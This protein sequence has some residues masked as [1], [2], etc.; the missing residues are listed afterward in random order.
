MS[1]ITCQKYGFSRKYYYVKTSETTCYADINLPMDWIM[2]DIRTRNDCGPAQC[3][4]CEKLLFNG[5][6]VYYC[7]KCLTKLATYGITDRGT[8]DNS[9]KVTEDE[10]LW[11]K[12]PYMAGVSMKNIGKEKPAIVAPVEHNSLNDID[13]LDFDSKRRENTLKDY[14][15][16]FDDEEDHERDFHTRLDAYPDYDDDDDKGYYFD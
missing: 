4:C 16:D 14:D 1:I 10:Q 5:V 6:F 7:N 8:P 9:D 11:L 15:F 13:D 3:P 12:A 2:N